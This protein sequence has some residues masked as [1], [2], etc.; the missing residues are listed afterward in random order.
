MPDLQAVPIDQ[1]RQLQTNIR[2]TISRVKAVVSP[3]KALDAEGW[4][5][6]TRFVVES[7]A[8][9]KSATTMPSARKSQKAVASR[10]QR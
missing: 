7:L 1:V 10:G 8:S 9:P 6:I 4:E 3:G 5:R 2:D